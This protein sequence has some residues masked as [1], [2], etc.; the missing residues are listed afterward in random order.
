[1]DQSNDA[2]TPTGQAFK[3]LKKIN[4][5]GM[6]YWS[7]RDL[8]PCLGYTEWRKFEN[9]IKKARESCKQSGNDPGHHFVGA[10]K[11]IEWPRSPF[12]SIFGRLR[13]THLSR[14]SPHP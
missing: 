1:V 14:L 8:Q 9:A 5:H 4:Q 11:Q 3:S 10:A 13:G 6:E 12:R 2:P 7:A